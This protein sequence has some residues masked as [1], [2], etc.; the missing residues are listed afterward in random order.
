MDPHYD[1][2]GDQEIHVTYTYYTFLVVG[3]TDSVTFGGA[4]GPGMVLGPDQS[5]ESLS[6]RMVL[7]DSTN[8]DCPSSGTTCSSKGTG[9]LACEIKN[10]K[11]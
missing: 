4:T 3:Y 8:K 7:H 11:S 5:F 2:K 9:L 10:Q 6:V 1:Q